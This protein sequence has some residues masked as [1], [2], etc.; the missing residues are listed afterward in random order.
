[1]HNLDVEENTNEENEG[2]YDFSYYACYYVWVDWLR[3]DNSELE[4]VV[5]I[6]VE[7]YDS[8]ERL[9]MN[10]IMMHSRTITLEN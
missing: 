3:K 8:R 7:G 10:L 5:T 4:R 2:Y 1:M 6:N 9:L